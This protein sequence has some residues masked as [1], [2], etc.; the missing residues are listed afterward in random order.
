ML[1]VSLGYAPVFAM[2]VRRRSGE[3][4]SDDGREELLGGLKGILW[5][6]EACVC[7]KASE[8]LMSKGK[9]YAQDAGN[10]HDS[11]PSGTQASPQHRWCR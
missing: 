3:L 1:F 9:I 7:R 5:V 4:R 8:L 11:P 6:R 2:E 10:T